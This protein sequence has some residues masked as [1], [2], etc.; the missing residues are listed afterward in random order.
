MLNGPSCCRRITYGYWYYWR[1]SKKNLHEHNLI[2]KPLSGTSEDTVYNA[3]VVNEIKHIL[4]LQSLGYNFNDI[5]KILKV[6][7]YAGMQTKKYDEKNQLYN[8]W[9][10]CK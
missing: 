9:R 8:C 5:A 10:S 6:T 3:A 7:D 1:F 2:S 4:Q